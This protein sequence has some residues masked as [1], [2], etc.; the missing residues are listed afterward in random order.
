M[1]ENHASENAVFKSCQ[2]VLNMKDKY[3]VEWF[4][5]NSDRYLY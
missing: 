1:N 5:W 3:L 4:S 2:D